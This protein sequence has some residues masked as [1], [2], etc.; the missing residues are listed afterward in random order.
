M[1]FVQ[2]VNSLYQGLLMFSDDH[3]GGV[4]LVGK[5]QWNEDVYPLVNAYYLRWFNTYVD[6]R[7]A[8]VVV[9][10][11]A[12]SYSRPDVI[13]AFVENAYTPA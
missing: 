2:V 4:P 1:A 8:A 11:T 3:A 9:E 13:S 6:I 12:S 10:V 5:A 7:D